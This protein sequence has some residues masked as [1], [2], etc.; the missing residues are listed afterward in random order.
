[1]KKIPL[2]QVFEEEQESVE[3]KGTKK[4]QTFNISPTKAFLQ[5]SF[6]LPKP[7]DNTV[8]REWLEWYSLPVGN[9]ARCPKMD[10][11]IEGEMGKEALE[12][13]RK[14][15]WPRTSLLMP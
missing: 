3:E 15:S 8:R 4:S 13:D 2:T 1:M 14:L 10:S 6:C 7:V 11:I 12:S 5:T 9:E